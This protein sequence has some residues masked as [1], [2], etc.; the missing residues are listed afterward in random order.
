M[1]REQ[2]IKVAK[3]LVRLAKEMNAQGPQRIRRRE[4]G[5]GPLITKLIDE[6]GGDVAKMLTAVIMAGQKAGK[7]PSGGTAKM[8]TKLQQALKAI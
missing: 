1:T 7:I 6:T 4:T 8:I 2:R 3:R 5:M